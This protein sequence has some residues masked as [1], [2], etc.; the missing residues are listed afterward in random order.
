MPSEKSDGLRIALLALPESTP[1]SIYGLYEV[2][3]SAGRTWEQLTGE[4][5][6]VPILSPRIV[7]ADGRPVASPYGLSIWPHAAMGE[8]DVVIVT[9][10]L[11]DHDRPFEGLWPAQI[12]WLRAQYAAGGIICSVCTGTALLAEAGLLDGLEATTH[13]SIAETIR[14][15]YPAVRLAAQKILVPAGPEHRIITGGGA[16]AWEELALYL[17]ARFCGPPE[18]V[19]I[20]K[21]FLFGD[22]SEGQLPFAGAQR[23]RTH[24]DAV[25]AEMQVWIADN[26]HRANPVAAMIERS[27]L[28]ERTFMRRFR[29]ATGFAAMEYVQMMRV[30]EAKHLLET[31]DMPVEQVAIE[32]GYEDP[33]FF[34]RLFKRRVGVTPARYRQRFSKVRLLAGQIG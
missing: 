19:R 6:E 9:D 2:F 30:E 32:V 11:L 24:D 7:T 8:A 5:L 10:L 21:I 28:T 12:E 15:R 13:W 16:T 4:R 3:L 25:I 29:A 27:G 18:A 33:N 17:V 14:R 31:T 1:A 20:A 23:P 22:H 34:R 26:Y